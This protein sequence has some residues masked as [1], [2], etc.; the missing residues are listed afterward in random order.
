MAK[1]L[2]TA[3]LRD[4]GAANMAPCAGAHL[5][6]HPCSLFT[7]GHFTSFAKRYFSS[8]APVAFKEFALKHLSVFC[9]GC[10]GGVGDHM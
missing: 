4:T 7:E 6:Q 9:D 2:H 3:Q 10:Q 8:R 1:H 5:A